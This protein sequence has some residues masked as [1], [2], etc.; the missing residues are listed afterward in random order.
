MSA[1]FIQDL[2]TKIRDIS[3]RSGEQNASD[4]TGAAR[5]FRALI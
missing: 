1:R 4:T 2:R 3:G 5:D